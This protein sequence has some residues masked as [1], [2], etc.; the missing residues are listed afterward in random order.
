M[1]SQHK[2]MHELLF[3]LTGLVV[4]GM[5]AIAGG[6]ML[7]GFPILLLLGV[8]PLVANATS[9][10]IVLPG[11]LASAAGYHEY[12]RKTPKKYAWLLV[13]CALGAPIGA[14]LL[15]HTSNAKFEQIAPWLILFAVIRFAL[16]PLMLYHLHRHMR[17]RSSRVKPLALIGL[18][19]FPVTIYGGYF[20]AGLGFLMLAFLGFTKIHDAH[21]MNAMKNVG[22]TVTCVTVLAVLGSSSLIDWPLGLTMGAGSLIGGYVGARMAQKVSSHVL[23]IVVICIGLATAAYLVYRFH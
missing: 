16:Q 19:L 8:N 4:G 7:L 15:L 9:A 17:T 10:V 23:R 14:Y 13:P 18:G 5:N 2:N 20:G 22:A 6:G 3:F 12:L 21:Q 11:Q 1:Q